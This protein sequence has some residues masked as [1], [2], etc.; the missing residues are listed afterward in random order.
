STFEYNYTGSTLENKPSRDFTGFTELLKEKNSKYTVSS[1]IRG[2]SSNS[3][4][5]NYH[6]NRPYFPV[7]KIKTIEKNTPGNNTTKLEHKIIYMGQLFN[8]FLLTAI[9]DIFYFIDQ[10]AAHE[11]IIFNDL[12]EKKETTQELL[13][14][15][16]FDLE[17]SKENIFNND[18]TNYKSLGFTFESLGNNKWQLVELPAICTGKEDIIINFIQSQK[19]T[20]SDLE[21]ELYA[22][23]A[24]KSAIKDGDIIDNT[25][26]MELIQKTLNLKNAR[27]PHG[28]PVWFQVSREELFQF[29]GRT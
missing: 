23:M 21:T 28:R 1:E 7:D 24:C 18:L 29:V 6:S 3:Y 15:F 4:L 20:I 16:L 9:D 2:K 17:S 14:P 26:A 13:I 11:K 8:L 10:H 12:K 19:G 27:C 5:P 25:T 22:D